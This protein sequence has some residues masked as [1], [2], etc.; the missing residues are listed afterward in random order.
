MLETYGFDWYYSDSHKTFKP[1]YPQDVASLKKEA[2]REGN[3]Y[4]KTFN[5]PITK[6]R[7][8]LNRF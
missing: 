2:Q 3:S 5:H 6:K 1:R 7:R 4:W 8:C